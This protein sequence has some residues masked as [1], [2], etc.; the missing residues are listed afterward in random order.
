M[1]CEINVNNLIKTQI[2]QGERT[3]NGR[4]PSDKLL[5]GWEHVH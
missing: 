2:E 5:P 1:P 4:S 3:D